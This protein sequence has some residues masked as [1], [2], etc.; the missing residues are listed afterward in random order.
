MKHIR[1]RDGPN[2]GHPNAAIVGWSGQYDEDGVVLRGAREWPID[3]AAN[4]R[5]GNP[6]PA[7]VSHEC[8]Q[9]E[10]VCNS[11]AY[12]TGPIRGLPEQPI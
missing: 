6:T 1:R 2:Q 5:G 9:E 4:Q 10:R 8:G 7:P 12:E 11:E 3:L